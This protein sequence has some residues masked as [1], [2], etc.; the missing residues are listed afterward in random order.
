MIKVL[1]SSMFMYQDNLVVNPE[2]LDD[3][4]FTKLFN[5]IIS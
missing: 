3:S 1:E 5:H 4:D 2:L